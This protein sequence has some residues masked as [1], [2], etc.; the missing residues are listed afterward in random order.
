MIQQRSFLSFL[1]LS[2]VTCGIYPIFW[3]YQMAAD[4]NTMLE[5]NESDPVLSAILAFIFMPAYIC[6]MAHRLYTNA[7]KVGIL[8]NHTWVFHMVLWIVSPLTCGITAWFSYY[9]LISDFNLM[10]FAYNHKR[11]SIVNENFNETASKLEED[12]YHNN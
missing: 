5:S 9:Y 10:L 1:L 8:L 6:I 2:I 7:H 4:T 11:G 3:A 12:S